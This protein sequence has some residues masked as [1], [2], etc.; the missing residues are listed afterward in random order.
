DDSG[1]AD[2]GRRGFELVAS[3]EEHVDPCG[4]WVITKIFGSPR[5]PVQGA[6]CGRPDRRSI[7]EDLF[8]PRIGVEW[9]A[10]HN[11]DG[12]KRTQD[13]GAERIGRLALYD[14]VH[15]FE[16]AVVAGRNRIHH[17]AGAFDKF[18][19]G[20]RSQECPVQLAVGRAQQRRLAVQS[21]GDAGAVS[22]RL[23][24]V[25]LHCLLDKLNRRLWAVVL[26][27]C[28]AKNHHPRRPYLLHHV[29]TVG[30]FAFVARGQ[31][32][33]FSTFATVGTGQP[34]VGYPM[35][36]HVVHYSERQR[37][38]LNDH[39]AVGEIDVAPEVDDV[40][41]GRQEE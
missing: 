7:G 34:E 30:Q 32:Q 14:L 41:V 17:L 39:W 20:L 40:G 10:L 15:H 8:H 25:D 13:F 23:I 9:L 29:T 36:P 28:A 31:Q 33:V 37:R 5:A 22:T 1:R 27:E 35:K 4:V 19:R 38:S 3:Y 11:A 26:K 6:S 2:L 16:I 21:G 12:R 24:R 18:R